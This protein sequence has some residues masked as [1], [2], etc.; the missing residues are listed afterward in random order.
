MTTR[1]GDGTATVM[2]TE[3]LYS[4]IKEEKATNIRFNSERRKQHAKVIFFR[5]RSPSPLL[6]VSSWRKREA[7]PCGSWRT[8]W[9]GLS[10]FCCNLTQRTSTETENQWKKKGKREKRWNCPK[11]NYPSI[12]PV[13]APKQNRTNVYP[14]YRHIASIWRTCIAAQRGFTSWTRYQ[15]S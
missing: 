3:A 7:A 12:S 2:S 6:I 9:H 1:M 10:I 8:S 4:K 15:T 13:G 11:T 14:L 5:H